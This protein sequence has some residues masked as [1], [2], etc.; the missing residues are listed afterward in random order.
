[1]LLTTKERNKQYYESHKEESKA[2]VL[3]FHEDHPEYR[4]EYHQR[5][6]LEALEHYGGYPPKCDCCGE[7]EMQFLTIDHM[8]SNGHKMRREHNVRGGGLGRL[9]KQLG[10]PKGYRVLCYNCNCSIGHYGFCP[11][12]GGYC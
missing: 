5:T 6:R 10:Y 2:R 9:L 8:D 7:T 12:N 3:K 1:M 11:H 4:R